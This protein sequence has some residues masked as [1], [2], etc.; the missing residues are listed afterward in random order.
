VSK[1]VRRGSRHGIEI[2]CKRVWQE[3]IAQATVG[4]IP[5]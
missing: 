3:A 2:E 1:C 5:S 4:G